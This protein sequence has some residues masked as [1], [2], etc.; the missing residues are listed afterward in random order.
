MIDKGCALWYP[1]KAPVW[2]QNAM[3][4]EIARETGVT[5]AEYVR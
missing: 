5:S 1:I 2:A 3:M 4:W